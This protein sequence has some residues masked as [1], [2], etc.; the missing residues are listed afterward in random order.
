MISE[1]SSFWL[2]SNLVN[3]SLLSSADCEELWPAC[4]DWFLFQSKW[5]RTHSLEVL[6]L[7]FSSLQGKFFL[8]IFFL[9][10]GVPYV[11]IP[12]RKKSLNSVYTWSSEH[13]LHITHCVIVMS[14]PLTWH[15]VDCWSLLWCT[16]QHIYICIYL[17]HEL[18]TQHV[19]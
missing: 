4:S 5:L 11:G 16:E 2:K 14:K 19:L 12:A 13:L 10:L 9:A 7:F 1:S 6:G 15:S 3:V 18:I 8:G 17:T